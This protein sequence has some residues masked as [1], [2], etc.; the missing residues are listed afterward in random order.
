MNGRD[1]GEDAGVLISSARS[2]V[3]SGEDAGQYDISLIDD[4]KSF[5]VCHGEGGV[6]SGIHE[7]TDQRVEGLFQ[8]GFVS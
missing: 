8:D 5:D 2:G 6:D 3:Y 4:I 7:S 1:S